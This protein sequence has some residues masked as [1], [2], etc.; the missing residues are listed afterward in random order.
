M[1]VP[2]RVRGLYLDDDENALDEEEVD[3][4]DDEDVD[5]L[6]FERFR[7]TEPVGEVGEVWTYV[8]IGEGG[9]SV[10]LEDAAGASGG[11]SDTIV[12]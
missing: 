11:D 9:S 7:D 3:V 10:L 5:A 1:T 6:D 8:G 12:V 4:V 2:D